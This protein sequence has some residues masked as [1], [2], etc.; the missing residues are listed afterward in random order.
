MSKY[1]KPEHPSYGTD[2]AWFLFAV[3]NPK[4]SGFGRLLLVEALNHAAVSFIERVVSDDGRASSTCELMSVHRQCPSVAIRSDKIE[5]VP[6]KDFALDM[7]DRTKI[8]RDPLAIEAFK[9][10]TGEIRKTPVPP[11]AP[12]MRKTP[13]NPV[14]KPVPVP[15]QDMKKYEDA[16]AALTEL[17]YKRPQAASMLKPLENRLSNMTMEEIIRESLRN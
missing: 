16:M 8:D 3:L 5:E 12:S 13:S 2:Q 7:V 14:M 9:E 1:L 10:A 4:G 6:F 11:M 17:G 15:Q